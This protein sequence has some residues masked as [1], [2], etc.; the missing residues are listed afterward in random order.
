MRAADIP[1]GPINQV[2]E[3][4]NDPHVKARG[5]IVEL[6]HPVAGL[7]RSLG[8]PVKLSATPAAYRLPPPTLGQH[9]AEVLGELGYGPEEVERLRED[10]VV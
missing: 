5:M 10:G 9:T 7:V 2:D 1:C 8:N 3:I 6:E 4:L